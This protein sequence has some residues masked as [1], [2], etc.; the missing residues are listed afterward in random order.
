MYTIP[1][2]L[3]LHKTQYEFYTEYEGYATDGLPNEGTGN[4]FKETVPHQ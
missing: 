1:H 4:C 2:N 3:N